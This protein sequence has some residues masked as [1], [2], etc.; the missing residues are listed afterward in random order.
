MPWRMLRHVV[1]V[2]KRHVTEHPKATRLPLVAQVAVHQGE[3]PTPIELRDLIDIDPITAQAI[4]EHLPRFRFRLGD[5]GSVDPAHMRTLLEAGPT[6]HPHRL[7]SSTASTS[8]ATSVAGNRATGPCRGDV[9]AGR[10]PCT[11]K[12]LPA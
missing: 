10:K 12:H 9:P 8:S 5:I 4:E 2:W 1:R 3:R 6:V 7:A 11:N